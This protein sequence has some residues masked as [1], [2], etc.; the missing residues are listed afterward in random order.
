MGLVS[1]TRLPCEVCAWVTDLV[2]EDC[3]IA[4]RKIPVC[5]LPT[6]RHEHEKIHHAANE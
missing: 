4:G 1:T 2:C 5:R 3:E 6:C